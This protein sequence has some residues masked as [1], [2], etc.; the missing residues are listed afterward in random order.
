MT[1]INCTWD[2][3]AFVPLAGYRKLCDR[4][5]VVGENYPLELAHHRSPESHR[6]Y[7]AALHQAW[8]NLPELY[9]D[10]WPSPEHLRKWALVQSG[11]REETTFLASS[12]AEAMR[13]AAF[14][15]SL[16]EYAVVNVDGRVV[17]HATAKSQSMKAMSRTEFNQS[18]QAVL[19]IV[20]KL[21]GVESDE[22]RANAGRAA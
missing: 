16:D 7:F 22:L 11:Y 6:H 12:K 8:S 19:D 20:A 9:A 4:L 3:D 10:R 15:R 1:P 2:G 21:I 5:F 14:M 18:K 17:T 13:L